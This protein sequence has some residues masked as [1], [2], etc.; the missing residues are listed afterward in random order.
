[1]PAV[2]YRYELRRGDQLV[3]TGRL[4]WE[5]VLE[6]GDRITIGSRKESC[7]PSSRYLASVSGAWSYNSGVRKSIPNTGLSSARERRS[8]TSETAPRGLAAALREGPA[9]RVES[10]LM[11]GRSVRP[12]ARRDRVR[13]GFLG[14]GGPPPS[15]ARRRRLCLQV[16]A[17]RLPSSI[18]RM[19]HTGFA[20]LSRGTT[21]GLV[22]SSRLAVKKVEK[23]VICG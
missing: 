17:D 4:T 11:D 18:H 23:A 19:R 14:P 16:V 6:V 8:G 5:E 15:Q 2:E 10:V 12:A 13:E 22:R 20:R 21:P 7:E 1:V 3:A 9:A